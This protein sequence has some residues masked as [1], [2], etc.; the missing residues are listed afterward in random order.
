MSREGLERAMLLTRP[1]YE[2]YF[3]VRSHGAH[4]IPT[5]GPVI[6]ASNHS[7]MLPLDAMMICVDA[8]MNAPRPRVVRAIGDYFIPKMPVLSTFFARA[9]VII[10]SRGN[11][12]YA[13][14]RGELLLI[15]PEGSPGIGKSF[16]NRYQL[17]PWR[18]GHAELAIRHGATVVPVAVIGAEEQWPVIGRLKGLHPFGV[19]YLPVPLT[20]FPLPVRYHIHYGLPIQLGA[21]H[22]PEDADDPEGVAA[23]AE[24]IK[25]SVESLISAGLAERKGIFS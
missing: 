6:L 9:G 19:P 4:N 23:A 25:L 18:V 15:F 10:G 13:L 7:G 20:P 24:R 3:R 16:W 12:R 14:E 2:W 22:R 8:F 17:A 5:D 21:Q 11:V 1:L